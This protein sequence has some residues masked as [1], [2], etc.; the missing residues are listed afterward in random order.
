MRKVEARREM[1]MGWLKGSEPQWLTPKGT[2]P[3]EVGLPKMSQRGG[4]DIGS[5][6]SH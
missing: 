6:V 5:K 4:G 3:S 2:T 1:R